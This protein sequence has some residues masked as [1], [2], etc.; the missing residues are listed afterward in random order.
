MNLMEL[1]SVKVRLDRMEE[2]NLLNRHPRDDM[3]GVEP[4]KL[5]LNVGE[6]AGEPV[7]LDPVVPTVDAN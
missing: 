1:Q 3:V 4:A 6:G 7:N 2:N 5:E